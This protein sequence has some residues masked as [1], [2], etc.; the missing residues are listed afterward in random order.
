[1][2]AAATGDADSTTDVHTSEIGDN[3]LLKNLP[4]SNYWFNN[5][6]FKAASCNIKTSEKNPGFNFSNQNISQYRTNFFLFEMEK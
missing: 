3:E 1:M 5:L 4:I 2:A 6:A